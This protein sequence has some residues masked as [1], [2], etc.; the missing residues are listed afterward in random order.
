MFDSARRPSMS[1][2]IRACTVTSSAVVGSSAMTRRGEQPIAMAIIARCRSPPESC[3]RIGSRGA[4]GLG[5][6]HVFEQL[7]CPLARVPLCQSAMQHQGLS[8]LRAH[9]MQRIERRHRLLEDHGDAVAAQFPHRLFI[10]ADE[11]PPLEADRTGDARALRRE[12]HQRQGCH[13]LAGPGFAHDPQA[14][15]LGERK[16][17]AIDDA[18]QASRRRAGRRR[19]RRLRAASQLRAFSLGSSASR[20]PSPRRLRPS[21]LSAIATPG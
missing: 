16:R 2:R 7:D 8:D 1:A 4:F 11:F 6:A 21:T 14:L 9:A 18:L 20:R 13:R 19:A 17:G 5:Q 15:A 12:A 3:E 10:E